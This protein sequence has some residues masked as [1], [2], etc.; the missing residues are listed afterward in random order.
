MATLNY[1]DP[2]KGGQWVA[3]PVYA[4]AAGPP[5]P[6][7]EPGPVVI[8]TVTGN[9]ASLGT[10][11][12]LFVPDTGGLDPADASALYVDVVGDAMTGELFVPDQVVTNPVDPTVAA[13]R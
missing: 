11:G 6:P 9:T 4:G 8:S 10:D 2:A 7:G 3:I 5:G 12:Q 13:A 1:R